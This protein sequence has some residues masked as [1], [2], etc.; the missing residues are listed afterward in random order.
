MIAILAYSVVPQHKWRF[1]ET[2]MVLVL[3][4]RWC[5]QH[6]GDEVDDE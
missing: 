2:S 3:D 1:W 4:T 6:E 5:I